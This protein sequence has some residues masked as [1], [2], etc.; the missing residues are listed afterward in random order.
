LPEVPVYDK[1]QTARTPG[2]SPVAQD[3]CGGG[4]VEITVYLGRRGR[5]MTEDVKARAETFAA[6]L[7]R[8]RR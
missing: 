6:P 8:G 7:E 1:N 3:K 4:A 5:P 2:P